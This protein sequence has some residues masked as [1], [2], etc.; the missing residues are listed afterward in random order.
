MLRFGLAAVALASA[1]SATACA[2]YGYGGGYYDAYYDNYYGPVYDGYWRSNYF[3]YR[4]APTAVFVIDRDR[5]FRRHASPGFNHFRY[6]RHDD[7][8]GRRHH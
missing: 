7:R 4:T 2:E 1:L 6:Q 8:H 3:Y 5:H